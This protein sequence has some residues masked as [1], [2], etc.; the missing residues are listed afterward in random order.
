M[1]DGHQQVHEAHASQRRRTSYS[2]AR[3][4]LDLATYGRHQEEGR[5][6][7]QMEAVCNAEGACSPII[8]TVLMASEP[9]V[10]ELGHLASPWWLQPQHPC[11]TVS[12]RPSIEPDVAFD[13]AVGS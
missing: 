8:R 5:R 7:G 2:Q 4:R 10:S 6:G 9:S 3:H 11:L 13:V 1:E 12:S